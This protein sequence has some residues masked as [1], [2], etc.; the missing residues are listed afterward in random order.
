MKA[1]KKKLKDQKKKY[2]KAR[3]KRQR[4]EGGYASSSS[5]SSSSSSDSEL[6]DGSCCHNKDTSDY[7][8]K[9]NGNTKAK[10]NP[11]VRRIKAAT[12]SLAKSNN[13]GCEQTIKINI[14]SS[15]ATF[16]RTLNKIKNSVEGDG[17]AAVAAAIPV[18]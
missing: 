2:K 3:R 4:R 12:K 1:L 15:R 14:G 5:S 17:I 16:N 9:I 11:I 7:Y 18:Y 6:D 8:I 13:N 10:P